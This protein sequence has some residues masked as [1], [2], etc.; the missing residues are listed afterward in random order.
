MYSNTQG[1]ETPS[2]RINNT[3]LMCLSTDI[4]TINESENLS[5]LESVIS[6]DSL[7]RSMMKCKSGVI[8]KGSV[9]SFVLNGIERTLKLE[10]QLK[11]GT[12]KASPPVR[13]ILTSPKRREILSITFKDRVYQRSLNDNIIYPVMVK[14]FIYDN[15]ACQKGKGT[16]FARNRLKTFLHKYYRRFGKDGYVLKIDI[17]GYYPNMRHDIC[18]E[19]FR[20]K[21]DSWTYEKTVKVLDEQYCGDIGF[22]AGSQLIQIAGISVL[23]GIDHYAKDVLGIKYYIRYMD[24]IIIIHNDIDYLKGIFRLI[25]YEISKLGFRCHETKTRIYPLKE[26]IEFL[27]FNFRLT[28]SGKVL[29][30]LK[31]DN[32]KRERKKL[33]R[34]VQRVNKGL[35]TKQKVDCCFQS[36]KAHASHGNNHK[37]IMRMDSYY[38]S[39]WKGENNGINKQN[40][41]RTA[42]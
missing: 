28:E 9:A 34:L 12:Y 14:N 8:W 3:D 11:D 17:K 35:I 38:K 40:E 15:C 10:N 16:D 25:E 7:Y 18:K 33:F 13:F 30:L 22:N 6:F 31:S 37:I 41:S 19:T 1:T 4:D 32:V 29:Q 23:N 27:G 42:E 24:D 36:W 2:E 20:K 39:L 26:G 5:I 21:L